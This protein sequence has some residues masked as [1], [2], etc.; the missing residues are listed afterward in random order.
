MKKIY[1]KSLVAEYL[2]RIPY[3]SALRDLRPFLFLTQYEKGEFITS[4]FQEEHLFQ[5]VV[6]GSLNIYFIRDNGT[7][8]SLSSGGANYLLGEMELFSRRTG[9]VYA[10][11][12]EDL[13]CIAL[14][15]EKNRD[16]ILKSSPFLQLLCRCLTEKMEAVTTLEAAPSTLK[17]RVLTYMKYKCAGGELKGLQNAAF[18]LNCSSR[19]LQRILNQYEREGVVEKTGK[20]S[21]RLCSSVQTAEKR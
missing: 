8:H 13:T 12:S 1:D 7:I 5:I 21:Y 15:I 10:E 17:E 3:E 20:G 9:S 16:A 11:A 2:S 18:H 19:Q 14:S 4:P 6:Q